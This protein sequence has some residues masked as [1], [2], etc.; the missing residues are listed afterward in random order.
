MLTLTFFK[1]SKDVAVADL[2]LNERRLIATTHPA[3][4][5][6]AMFAMERSRL[7]VVTSLGTHTG[8]IEFHALGD[9][10]L[11][12]SVIK[13]RMD[14]NPRLYQFSHLAADASQ[15]TVLEGLDLF[16]K[17]NWF[18]PS[19][20]CDEYI[21]VAYHH[22]PADVVKRE[23]VKPAPTGW[24]LTLKNRNDFIYFPFC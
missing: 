3:T 24:G 15:K 2:Y 18:E 10:Q 17:D 12:L 23:L 14:I 5:V 6:G 21:R 9:E 16:S 20:V 13:M 8:N 22:L 7:K 19:E 1:N 4:I 11:P